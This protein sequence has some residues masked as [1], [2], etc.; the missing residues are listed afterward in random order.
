MLDLNPINAKC[1]H[2]AFAI[3]LD[4]NY[5]EEQLQALIATPLNDQVVQAIV[6]RHKAI[7]ALGFLVFVAATL[8]IRERPASGL[9]EGI[10][11]QIFAIGWQAAIDYVSANGVP[12]DQWDIA[13]LPRGY[14][15]AREE[16]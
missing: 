8:P 16:E 15:G 10:C 1:L 11:N 3:L 13:S 6:D 5:D 2:E 14:K 4:R 7:S 12:V 9:H